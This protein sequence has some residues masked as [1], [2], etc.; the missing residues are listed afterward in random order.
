MGRRKKRKSGGGRPRIQF[1]REGT[2][3][4]RVIIAGVGAVGGFL[5]SFILDFITSYSFCSLVFLY[6]FR[7]FSIIRS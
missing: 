7:F 3:Y 6:F 5:S 4:W 1:E 2:T